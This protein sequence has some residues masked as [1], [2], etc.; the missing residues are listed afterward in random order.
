MPMQAWEDDMSPEIIRKAEKELGET[1]EVKEQALKDLR[2]LINEESDFRPQTSDSFLL[3]FLRAKKYDI[4]RA[5]KTLQNYY[6]FKAR[7]SG[8]ITDF[9]PKDVRNVIEMNNM[10]IMPQRHPSG[11]AVSVAR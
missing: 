2:R 10:L 3:R 11:A 4:R 7:Y 1:P 6:I 9:I 8:L 5:F